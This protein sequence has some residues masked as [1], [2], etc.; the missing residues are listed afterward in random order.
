MMPTTVEDENHYRAVMGGPAVDVPRRNQADE[1]DDSIQELLNFDQLVR[2]P[3]ANINEWLRQNEERYPIIVA[4][5]E[6]V[7]SVPASSASVERLFS[8]AGNVLSDLRLS[9]NDSLSCAI[10]FMH[11]NKNWFFPWMSA[12]K[13]MK[14]HLELI[15][16]L[17]DETTMK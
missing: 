1:I 6:D 2:D 16:N 3:L 17:Y 8:A 10:M 15:Q 7:F 12:G 4:C 9:L 11:Y 14:P 13:E 5:A